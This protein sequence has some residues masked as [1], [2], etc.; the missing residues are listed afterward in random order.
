MAHHIT[1]YDEAF[2]DADINYAS[3]IIEN[4]LNDKTEIIYS[5]LNGYTVAYPED[6]YFESLGEILEKKTWGNW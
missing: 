5:N 3:E 6:H 2:I 4:I 1:S